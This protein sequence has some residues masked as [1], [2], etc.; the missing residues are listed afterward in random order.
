MI[1]KES[2]VSL[3]ESLLVVVVIGSIVFLFAL[4]FL[5]VFA[6][7]V[8][9]ADTTAKK[10]GITYECG[11]NSPDGKV[12]TSGNCDFADLVAAT[13]K[14]VN[15]GVTFALMFSVVVIAV[16]GGQY[17]FYSDN[18]AKRKEVNAMLWKVVIG[19]VFILAA[20]LIVTLITRALLGNSVLT[21]VPDPSTAR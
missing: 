13:R 19:I 6:H 10:T 21:S 11:D 16:A 3:I 15:F 2:G 7:A 9:S 14:A 18:P 12:A 1:K 20:W 4:V 17:M 5:P 8:A